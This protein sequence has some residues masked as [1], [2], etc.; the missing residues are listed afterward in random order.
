MARKKDV[1]IV[2]MNREW[3]HK[4]GKIDNRYKSPMEGVIA[5]ERGKHR[6]KKNT[7]NLY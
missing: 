2:E 1:K 4:M 5:K 6:R 7:L 3:L